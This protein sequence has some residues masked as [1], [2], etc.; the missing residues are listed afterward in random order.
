MSS[1]VEPAVS[2]AI[3]ESCRHRNDCGYR[4]HGCVTDCKRWKAA[5]AMGVSVI[6][7]IGMAD[8]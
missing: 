3:C 8:I 5:Y 4:Y 1:E 6:F 2:A 7:G